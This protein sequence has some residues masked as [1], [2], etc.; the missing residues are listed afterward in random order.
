MI[1]PFSEGMWAGVGV[2]LILVG[3][4]F[5][6]FSNVYIF[7][8]GRCLK[9]KKTTKF[10]FEKL[11]L[12]K[13]TKTKGGIKEQITVAPIVIAMERNVRQHNLFIFFLF[14]K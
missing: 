14:L 7:L 9:Q 12:W 6:L 4:V 10:S 13:R 5:F 1:L 11:K 8:Q 2:S 3:V